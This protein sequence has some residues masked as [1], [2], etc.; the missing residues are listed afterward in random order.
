MGKTL[1]VDR[2]WVWALKHAAGR[3]DGLDPTNLCAHHPPPQ[4]G[5]LE[6]KVGYAQTG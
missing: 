3:T 4:V 2:C 5:P 1:Q 6:G